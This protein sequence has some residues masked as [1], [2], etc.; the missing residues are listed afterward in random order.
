MC[1]CV[2]IEFGSYDN[3]TLLGYYPIMREYRDNRVAAGLSGDGIP[4]DTCLVEQIIE[5][6]KAGVRTYGCCCGHNKADGFINIDPDDLPKARVLGL[7]LYE[8]PGNGLRQD[9]V[10]PR[11]S[12]DLHC[13]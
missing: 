5:L 1:N 2:D 3:Q 9:T 8:F 7:D 13:I 10:K 6:W 12:H 4:V 11:E